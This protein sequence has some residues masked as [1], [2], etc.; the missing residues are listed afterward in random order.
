MP[1]SGALQE[2]PPPTATPSPRKKHGGRQSTKP[3]RFSPQAQVNA[4]GAKGEEAQLARRRGKEDAAKP[5][6]QPKASN[7][8]KQKGKAAPPQAAAA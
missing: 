2:V 8:R 4:E 3:V 1:A 6:P 5:P 7:P